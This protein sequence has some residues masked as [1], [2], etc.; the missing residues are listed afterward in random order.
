MMLDG[1]ETTSQIKTSST[2]CAV[3]NAATAKLSSVAPAAS[4]ESL[5]A[6]RYFEIERSEKNTLLCFIYA[7]FL[8]DL[9]PMQLTNLLNFSTTNQSA[10]TMCLFS[11]A[12]QNKILRLQI[13]CDFN[14]QF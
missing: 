10:T 9:N 7:E 13:R 12:F 1:Q 2:R 3:L 14:R 4:A 8:L 11:P 6:F 5:I